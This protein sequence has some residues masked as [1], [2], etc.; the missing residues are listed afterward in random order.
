MIR[1]IRECEIMLGS[2][3]KQ[4]DKCEE[5]TKYVARRSICVSKDIEAGESITVQKITFQRPGYGIQPKDKDLIIG[6]KMKRNMPAGSILE[7]S[8]IA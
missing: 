8:D 2:S 5:E 7:W 1:K 6:K 4:P 3:I